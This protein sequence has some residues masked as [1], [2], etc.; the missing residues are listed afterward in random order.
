MM[1]ASR[2]HASVSKMTPCLHC[3][4]RGSSALDSSELSHPMSW[5]SAILIN[6]DNRDINPNPVAFDN[7]QG[8]ID[9][10]TSLERTVVS[11]QDGSDWSN[12]TIDQ[13]SNFYCCGFQLPDFHALLEHFEESHVVVLA[14]NG[15]RV[16]P[17]EGLQ[18]VPLDPVSS[19]TSTPDLSRASSATPTSPPCP[20][21]PSLSSPSSPSNVLS[22]TSSP[23]SSRKSSF[24]VP[25]VYTPFTPTLPIDPAYPFPDTSEVVIPPDINFDIQS[26]HIYRPET[27]E[28]ALESSSSED[29]EMSDSLLFSTDDGSTKWPEHVMSNLSPEGVSALMVRA[30][31]RFV[32]L[33]VNE[34]RKLETPK[35]ASS[36]SNKS[37]RHPGSSSSHSKRREKMY[38]CPVS[39]F[40]L[41]ISVR[42]LNIFP[43]TE[44]GMRQGK[45]NLAVAN[46]LQFISHIPDISQPQW[47]QVPSR[48][49][50]LQIC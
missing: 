28:I 47:T 19:G 11:Y 22:P 39:L 25:S 32:K 15:K 27:P 17:R 42:L 38:H 18:A 2:T 46:A 7:N 37:K 41:L 10:I 3:T 16:Y 35:V 12:L 29:E 40:I 33:G 13:C 4:N 9:H 8:N 31:Q 23:L 1:P 45:S 49:R 21:T 5:S 6:C 20:P 50:N 24:S 14:P 26:T 34:K 48:T 43:A 30:K 36:K 44:G